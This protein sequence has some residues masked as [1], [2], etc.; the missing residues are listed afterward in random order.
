MFAAQFTHS[1]ICRKP[2]CF[3]LVRNTGA[4]GFGGT[5][6]GELSTK[7]LKVPPIVLMF[8]SPIAVKKA[9]ILGGIYE[10]ISAL[11]SFAMM[12]TILPLIDGQS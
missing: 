4:R 5:S 8:P 3:R 7:I 10:V 2:T 11:A 6:K 1:W 12:M 9:L